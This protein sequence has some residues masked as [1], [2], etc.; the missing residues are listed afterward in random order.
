MIRDFA[1]KWFADLQASV[2]GQYPQRNPYALCF[3]WHAGA[4][5]VL[6]TC[7]PKSTEWAVHE[8]LKAGYSP[9]YVAE[10]GHVD[11]YTD[12][13]DDDEVW[14]RVYAWPVTKLTFHTSYRI[15]SGL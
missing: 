15:S 4:L 9:V 12:A 8:L 2:Q 5:K 3:C 14:E 1:A 13:P 7:T 10:H 6:S 11:E